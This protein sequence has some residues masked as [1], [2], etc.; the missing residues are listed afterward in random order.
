[1]HTKANQLTIARSRARTVGL[2]G[3]LLLLLL[4]GSLIMVAGPSG[5]SS[6]AEDGDQTVSQPSHAVRNEESLP[7]AALLPIL[8]SA[9][10]SPRPIVTHFSASPP[11]VDVGG[12]TTLSWHIRNEVDSLSLEP[13]IGDV[14]GR[15]SIV[16]SLNETT[17]YI[18]TAR[19]YAGTTS[20]QTIVT[21]GKPVISS[22]EAN[23]T[24]IYQ[25]GQS[26]LSWS[27][28]G[29]VDQ[30]TLEP[31]IGDVTGNTKVI[32]SP[33]Q[34]TVYTLTA[35]NPAGT[36][37]S[38]V[39]ITV[40]PPPVITS[41]EPDEEA[42]N[43]GDSTP[44]RWTISGTVQSL[45][46]EPG[47]GDVSGL[48]Q[49]NVSPTETTTYTLTAQNGSGSDMAMAL[50]RVSPDT[51]LL[52]FDW[53]KPVEKSD[54][55]FPGED[56]SG[57]ANDDWTVPPNFA[58]GTYHMR[59]EIHS[60][61]VAKE[62]IV[63]YCVWQKYPGETELREACADRMGLTGNPGVKATWSTAIEDMWTKYE[64][65]DYSLKRDR[66]RVVIRNSKGK[67]VTAKLGME[68]NGEDPDEWYPLDWRFTV[69]V[70][71]K[72]ATFSGWSNYLEP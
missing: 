42:I 68:W 50:V 15:E 54:S 51:E 10:S 65:I 18:L 16:L 31:G 30:L 44:L 63:Q 69:V 40:A 38:Q 43:Q 60:Q 34:D 57:E 9:I 21:V 45:V 48:S 47:F 39:E 27:I 8:R 46:L 14:T 36:A 70:V 62:M 28:L 66:H 49:V 56:T 61:P 35:T 59:V 22:F 53:N 19:N 29:R 72:D 7:Y 25:N 67:L 1:M 71:A 24:L 13:G 41:F 3:L 6:R 11:H 20:A 5:L 64:S 2:A 32:V 17:T 4:A 26:T 23:P 33:S 37:T 55:G 12:T 52:V 58:Q